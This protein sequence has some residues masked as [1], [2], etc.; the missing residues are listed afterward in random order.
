MTPKNS[1][2]PRV[3]VCKDGEVKYIKKEYLEEFIIDGWELGRKDYKP[4]KGHNG[5][6]IG[7]EKKPKQIERV[8]KEKVKTQKELQRERGI[9]LKQKQER[10]RNERINLILQSGIDFSKY[11]WVS[12]VSLIINLPPQ[13]VNVFMKKYMPDFYKNCFIRK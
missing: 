7:K 5:I 9:L 3:W 2:N 6:P 11:G 1:T 8:K 4:R 10:I 12:K 13:K